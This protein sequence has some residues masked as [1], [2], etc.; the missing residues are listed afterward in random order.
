MA[1]FQ[2]PPIYTI[3]LVQRFSKCCSNVTGDIDAIVSQV[4]HNDPYFQRLVRTCVTS[5]LQPAAHRRTRDIPSRIE[6]SGASAQGAAAQIHAVSAIRARHNIALLSGGGVAGG[7]GGVA[8]G[9]L[10]QG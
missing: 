6:L 4:S 1:Y 8:P 10:K 7:D 5:S 2:P 9:I 3:Q